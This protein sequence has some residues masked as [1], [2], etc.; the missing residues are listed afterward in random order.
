MLFEKLHSKND[1]GPFCDSVIFFDLKGL[2]GLFDN[3]LF[4]GELG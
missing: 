2:E 1:V 4:Y 3:I